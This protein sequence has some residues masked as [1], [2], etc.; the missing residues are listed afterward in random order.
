MKKPNC[1]SILVLDSA[2]KVHSVHG[3]GLLED[4]N[5]VVRVKNFRNLPLCVPLCPLR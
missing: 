3:P 5:I 1:A 2:N 4:C